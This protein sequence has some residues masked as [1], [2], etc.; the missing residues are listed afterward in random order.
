LN[1]FNFGVHKRLL[2]KRF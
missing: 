1:E 2:S